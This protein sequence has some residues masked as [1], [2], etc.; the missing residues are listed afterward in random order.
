MVKILVPSGA[1]GLDFD[2][3]ALERGIAQNPDIIAID[4]GSTDSGPSYLGRGVSKYS[5]GATKAEWKRLIEARQKAGCPLVIGTSGTCGTRSTVDWLYE[6]TCEILSELGLE[7]K[8]ARIY[9]DQPQTRVLEALDAGRITALAP[10]GPLEAQSVEACDHIVALAGVE[11][12][13]AALTRGAEII[14]AG[15]TTDTA[16]IAAHAIAQGADAGAAWHAAKVAEC[17]SLCTNAPHTGVIMVEIDATG[18]EIEPMGKEAACTVQTVFAHM[19]YENTDPWVLYEP[20]GRLDVT[21][22]KYTQITPRK[23]RVEGAIWH[24]AEEYTVKLEGAGQAGYQTVLLALIRDQD[25]IAR[26]DEWCAD[27]LTQHREKVTA[28]LGNQAGDYHVELRRI[29]M[30]AALG[31]IEGPTQAG[32]EV[33]ILGI[34]TAQS[35]EMAHEIG[36]MLNPFL[37]H[38]GLHGDPAQPTFAFAFSPPEMDRGALYQ[39]YLNHIMTI[40]DPMDAF[41]LEL[42]HAPHP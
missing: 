21:E 19:I 35:Q 20:G 6:I 1:L 15:R 16:I 41:E 3:S 12:I 8:V 31:P 25:Y 26:V 14:L 5:R 17:G 29:G 11:Q 36:K 32:P 4:G 7:A 30:D 37:L 24:P 10:L 18:F 27:V 28:A 42:S 33:G 34:V 22:A 23:V 9:S 39:F 38:H 2:Q 13:N 40:D